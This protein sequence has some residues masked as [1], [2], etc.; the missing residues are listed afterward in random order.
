[1][2][3]TMMVPALYCLDIMLLTLG[4]LACVSPP[5]ADLLH[6]LDSALVVADAPEAPPN[7]ARLCGL[8]A[9]KS[10]PTWAAEANQINN[11]CWDDALVVRHLRCAR[12][13]VA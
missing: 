11:I 10:D 3:G 4:A 2:K 6:P 8:A 7:S 1:M 12:R 5:P 9:H 13:H